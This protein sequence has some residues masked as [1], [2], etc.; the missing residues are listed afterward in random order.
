MGFRLPK[1]IK[2]SMS[3]FPA[4]RRFK[5]CGGFARR[6]RSFLRKCAANRR[7]GNWGVCDDG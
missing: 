4:E 6:A 7:R 1:K 3:Q 5:K 2:I